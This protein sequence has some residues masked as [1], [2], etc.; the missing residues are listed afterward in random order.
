MARILVIDDEA[1]VRDVLVKFLKLWGH[2]VRAAS[3]GRKGL[4]EGEQFLPDLLI[5]DIVMPEKDGLETIMEFRNRLPNVRIIAMSG[6][7]RVNAVDYLKISGKIGATA[8]LAKPFS[9]DELEAAIAKALG[10]QA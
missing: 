10:I 3:D 6:G 7:G 5:T 1:P 8:T 9:R 2:E 4:V